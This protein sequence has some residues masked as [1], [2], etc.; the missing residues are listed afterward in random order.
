MSSPVLVQIEP[1]IGPEPVTLP[2]HTL[3]FVAESKVLLRLAA[4]LVVAQLAQM[5]MSVVGTLMAGRIGVRA[6]AAQGLG[7][8]TFTF[9]LIAGY[10]VMAGLDP[11]ISRAVGEQKPAQV[12]HLLRQSLWLAL[13]VVLPLTALLV[14]APMLLR[15]MGQSPNLMLDVDI[16]LRWTLPGLLPALVFSAYR[17]FFSA[18]NRAQI[19]MYAAIAA[20]VLNWQLCE[21][22]SIHRATGCRPVWRAS[23]WRRSSAVLP[24]SRFWCSTENTINI[25]SLSA[26]VWSCPIPLRSKPCCVPACRWVCNTAWK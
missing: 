25:S 10:G 21:F 6:L 13:M 23:A 5:A 3:R 19:V 17:S 22:L 18:V 2:T 14:A 9:V 1:L 11:H 8:T 16:Y 24:W 20:N 12:G 15:I 7:A 4:P 26:A